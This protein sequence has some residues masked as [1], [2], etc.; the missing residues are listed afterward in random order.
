[1]PQPL[2]ANADVVIVGGGI[3]GCSIAYHLVRL[4][5]TNVVLLERKQLTCGTTWHAAGLVGQ[6]RASRNLTELA[7]YTTELFRTLEAETGQATGFKQTGSISVALTEGRLEEF[8]RGASMAKKLRS[9]GA[10]DHAGRDQGAVAAHRSRAA[11]RAA[12]ILPNDGQVNPIDVTQAYAAGARQRGAKI[13]ENTKVTRILMEGD[14]ATGVETEAGTIRA[15]AVVI[16]AGMWSRDIGR[17]AGVDLPLHAAEHFYIVTEPLDGL[18]R[19]LPV[20]RVPDECAY[21]K[22]DAGKLMLGAFEPG[23]KPWGMNGIPP[24]SASTRCPPTWTISSRC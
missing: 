5:I 11:S 10:G 6:L 20:M 8:R 15:D 23:A 3:I 16:A 1:M 13:F 19:D 18:A 9:R 7:K 12:C 17:A 2:P 21:Y 14:R 4:G 24:T 22:E